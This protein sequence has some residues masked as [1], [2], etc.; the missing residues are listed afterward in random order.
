MTQSDLC[1]PDWM[2]VVLEELK[3][4]ENEKLLIRTKRINGPK[5][6]PGLT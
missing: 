1:H 3:D 5:H 4:N 6:D 2:K